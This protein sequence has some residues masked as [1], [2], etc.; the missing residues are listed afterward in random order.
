MKEEKK[1][2][3]REI[4]VLD[5]GIKEERMVGPTG[6]CCGVVFIPFWPW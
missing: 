4:V 5:E 2:N 3:K 6:A 1:E